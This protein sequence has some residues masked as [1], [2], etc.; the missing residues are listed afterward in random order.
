MW[1]SLWV[2]ILTKLKLKHD[3]EVKNKRATAPKTKIHDIKKKT[4]TERITK[5]MM[6]RKKNPFPFSWICFVTTA[7]NYFF[8]YWCCCYVLSNRIKC[9]CDKNAHES[10]PHSSRKW[11]RKHG[12]MDNSQT[13]NTQTIAVTRLL[14][15]ISA[16]ISIYLSTSTEI[17]VTTNGWNEPIVTITCLFHQILPTNSGQGCFCLLCMCVYIISNQRI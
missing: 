15:K 16:H 6:C 17:K 5:H 11:E 8:C 4:S 10:K 13:M 14:H 2:K 1:K 9:K 3:K 7:K 12:R